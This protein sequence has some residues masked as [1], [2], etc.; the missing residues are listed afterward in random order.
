MFP[1]VC[2]V[3]A[4]VR[5]CIC[6]EIYEINFK[7]P[8]TTLKWWLMLV[9]IVVYTYVLYIYNIELSLVQEFDLCNS[10]GHLYYYRS[11]YECECRYKYMVGGFLLKLISRAYLS[12]KF[13]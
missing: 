7:S 2:G 4:A 9:F 3:V 10:A 1:V 6:N 8:T 11:Q 13:L 5:L 12:K